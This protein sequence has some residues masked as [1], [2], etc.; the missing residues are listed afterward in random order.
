[1]KDIFKTDISEYIRAWMTHKYHATG[2]PAQC[3]EEGTDE[4]VMEARKDRL[5]NEAFCR[6]GIVLD[7]E[8]MELNPGLRFLAKQGNI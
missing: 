8:K 5:F 6:Y 4:L 3:V 7:R 2:W 1:L